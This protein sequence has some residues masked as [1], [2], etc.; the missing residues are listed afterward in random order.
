MFR[1]LFP[2]QSGRSGAGFAAPVILIGILSCLPSIAVSPQQRVEQASESGEKLAVVLH[3]RSDW[4]PFFV[5]LSEPVTSPENGRVIKAGTRAV[6][7]RVEDQEILADFGRNGLI[8]LPF[9][10]TNILHEAAKLSR[11]PRKA[12]GLLSSELFNKFFRISEGRAVGCTRATFGEARYVLF[13]YTDLGDQSLD[14]FH[15]EINGFAARASVESPELTVAAIPSKTTE[16]EL[17]KNCL[18]L[19]VGFP[20]MYHF[21]SEG[22]R[23]VLSHDI[24]G[25]PALVLVDHNGRI[26][27]RLDSAGDPDALNVFKNSLQ[28][29][30]QADRELIY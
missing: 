4:W 27:G 1:W 16:E 7:I 8:R 13:L 14:S 26:L 20:V 29:I 25:L 3:E 11:Q 15:H 22:Y 10:K 28:A 2:F 18:R 5:R 12:D 9:S 19:E 30:I 6:L 21:L 24:A 23:R 17:V